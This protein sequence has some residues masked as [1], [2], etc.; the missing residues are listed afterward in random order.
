[1][2]QSPGVSTRSF[3]IAGVSAAIVGTAVITPANAPASHQAKVTAA[4]VQLT[5]LASGFEGV[6][7][8]V[9]GI[10]N[11]LA[12]VGSG[13]QATING[14]QATI[15]HVASLPDGVQ[16]TIKNSYNN[17]ERWPA[18]GADLAQ[19]SLAVIPGLWWA[20]PGIGLSYHT[21]EPLVRAGAYSFADLVG[22]DPA[23]FRRDISD[24][25]STSAKNAATYGKAWADSF[26]PVPPLPDYPTPP[27]V[28]SAAALPA[29]STATVATPRAAAVTSGIEN[30]IKNTYNAV[31][32][33]VAW[34]FQLAQWGMGFVPG[35]WWVA[36]GVSLAYFSIEP[37]VQA[38]VYT[39]ADVLG[40]NFAQIGPDIQQGI[41]QSVQNFVNYGLAWLGSLIPFPPLPPFPPRPGA[42]VA[43]AGTL[44]AAA[45]ISVTEGAAAETAPD[46]IPAED[47]G[48]V[49]DGASKSDTSAAQ[50]TAPAVETETPS[51]STSNA[52]A[53]AVAPVVDGTIPGPETVAPQT[54]SATPPVETVTVAGPEIQAPTPGAEVKAPAT[55]EAS[56]P[57]R[58]AIRG[59]RV[60]AAQSDN[61]GAGNSAKVE[62]PGGSSR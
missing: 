38:G 55:S 52:P 34:G 23:Q 15:D 24:G 56:A 61:A 18:Y 46:V 51:A 58:G 33:W 8:G 57:S 59:H 40:L 14:I 21:A 53:D 3:L 30:A 20:A 28:L 41:Q 42:S 47:S 48:P 54:E 12:Q 44:R 25:I 50:H 49:G 26:V 2:S 62:R 31:E 16:A 7:N 35:L 32:P 45:A 39:V 4:A 36:P 22:L 43:A 60:P 9:E 27:S 13:I 6:V 1:M 37:L 17:A 29:A 11:N 10:F 5:S 19:F